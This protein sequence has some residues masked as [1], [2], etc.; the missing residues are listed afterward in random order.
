VTDRSG[1]EP[2]PAV[3]RCAELGRRLREAIAGRPAPTWAHALLAWLRSGKAKQ[4]ERQR[5]ELLADWIDATVARAD[6]R[7][8]ALWVHVE[9]LRAL[10]AEQEA[11]LRAATDEADSL[12]VIAEEVRALHASARAYTDA[13]ADA[14]GAHVEGARALLAEQE[15]RIGVLAD[16]VRVLD[17]RLRQTISELRAM[18]RA[19]EIAGA[20]ERPL[21]GPRFESLLRQL[22]AALPRL[23]RCTAVEVSL[24]SAADEG[25]IAVAEH[26]LGD[27]LSAL[28]SPY[29][30]PND[31]W[32]HVD[33]TPYSTRAVLLENAA[34]RLAPGGLLVVATYA[35]A[36][37]FASHPDLR[38][39][40]NVRLPRAGGSTDL[41]AAV[42][43]RA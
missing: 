43:E 21:D 37:G 7:A 27:R 28:A 5:D 8:D 30:A 20:A 38:R 39:L 15:A 33:F 29:R 24:Q 1:S 25:L 18:S 10:L 12:P 4:R 3:E 32:I 14:I 9:A 23:E 17:G 6:A 42:W 26:L 41:E 31:A 13:R 16:E 35:P 11:R 36:E 40:P 2:H 22:S 19:H 34:A